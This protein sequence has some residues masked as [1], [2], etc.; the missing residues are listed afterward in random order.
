MALK[1]EAP[2]TFHIAIGFFYVLNFI[3]GTGFLGIPYS[4]YYSGYLA[5]IPTMLFA[6]LACGVNA[7]YIL[8]C[9]ARAQVC[10]LASLVIYTHYMCI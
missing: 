7:N 10:Q 1:S 9:M 4:F 5:A 3:V 8:E 6:M 2:K